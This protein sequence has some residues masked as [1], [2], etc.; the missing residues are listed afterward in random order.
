[1]GLKKGGI[2]FAGKPTVMDLSFTEDGSHIIKKPKW[3]LLDIH[4]LK[5]DCVVPKRKYQGK[6]S[7]NL[8]SDWYLKTMVFNVSPCIFFTSHKECMQ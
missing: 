2:I 4:I 7:I 3:S 5:S 1:M 8:L 6:S